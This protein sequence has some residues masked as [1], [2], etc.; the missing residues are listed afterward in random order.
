VVESAVKSYVLGH[1]PDAVLHRELKVLAAQERGVIADVLAHIAEVDFRKAYVPEAYDSISAYCVGELRLSEDAAA[2]RIQVARA[3]RQCPAIFA[4]L[5][6]GHVH[7]SGLV[8]LAPHLTPENTAELLAAATHKR[9]SEIERLVAERFPKLPSPTLLAP[10]PSAAGPGEHAPGH[11]HECARVTPVA[12][13]KFALQLTMDEST[14][15][16][17]RYAQELLGHQVPDGDIATV[18]DRALDLLVE[19][20]ERT[21]FR[22][23]DRPGRPGATPAPGSHYVPAH[24][25]RVVVKRDQ[26]RCAYVSESGRRCEARKR[27]EFDH[28]VPVARGG[29]STVENV[30]LRCRAHNQYEAER[31]YGAEFMSRKR[32]E[33]AERRA[34]SKARPVVERAQA[35][36]A[37][38]EAAAHPG[39]DDV[40]RCLLALGYRIS[41]ARWAMA[42]SGEMPGATDEERVKR[43]L[44]QFPQRATRVDRSGCVA[45][46]RAEAVA[47]PT[48]TS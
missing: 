10:S 33:S 28:E 40:F 32:E 3:G 9:K 4:A 19:R 6:E 37:A 16:K 18:L 14:H 42:R 5:S 1:L 23:T 12:P 11:V 25:K 26:C 35:C 24:V 27:L 36:A 17:L 44:A 22:I 31:T 48:A 2:K 15:D 47:S 34:R 29:E 43:A 39:E 30:R 45:A 20:L 41:E 7:L 38:Q 8:L 46:E 21:R 13:Q